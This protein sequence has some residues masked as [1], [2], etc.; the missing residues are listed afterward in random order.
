M[1]CLSQESVGLGVYLITLR[2]FAFVLFIFCFIAI[3][4]LA[5][6]MRANNFSTTY[7]AVINGFQL[8]RCTPSGRTTAN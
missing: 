1:V 2:L 3:Y 8:V 5:A 6:N 7:A 4:P